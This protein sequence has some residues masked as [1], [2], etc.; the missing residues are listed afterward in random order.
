VRGYVGGGEIPAKP[1]EQLQSVNDELSANQTIFY[2]G[3]GYLTMRSRSKSLVRSAKGIMFSNH[4]LVG[5]DITELRK[6]ENSPTKCRGA[7]YSGRANK[8]K[9]DLSN[10]HHSDI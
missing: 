5:V 9:Y 8:D 6:Q 4:A 3:E 7:A 1:I 2:K 10:F